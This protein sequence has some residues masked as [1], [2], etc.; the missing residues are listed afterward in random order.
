MVVNAVS[1]SK[2]RPCVPDAIAKKISVI[3][4]EKI[5][6]VLAI[7]ILV[8]RGGIGVITHQMHCSKP[9]PIEVLML[10][11]ARLHEVVGHAR[12]GRIGVQAS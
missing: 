10:R 4:G 1:V 3:T 12:R 8:I 6:S 2:A 9:L 7:S 5:P 11:R